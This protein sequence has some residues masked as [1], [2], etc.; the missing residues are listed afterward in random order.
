MPAPCCGSPNQGVAV[1]GKYVYVA[2]F[3]RYLLALDAA[4]GDKVWDVVVADWR[5][6]Y[7]MTG[8]P[9]AI[10]DRIVVGIAGGDLG[11]RGFLTAYSASDGTQLWK[12]YTVPGPGQ[13]GH[14]TGPT[15]RGSMVVLP[16]GPRVL[17]IRLWDLCIGEPAIQAPYS[18][19][20]SG[21][22]ITC[23]RVL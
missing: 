22:A 5:R 4:T 9:L 15:T 18:T 20:R 16:H 12:F 19:P 10:D 11:V 17:T 6:G 21:R 7:S 1:L 2:T 23:T 8:A 14:E 13:P 3:D